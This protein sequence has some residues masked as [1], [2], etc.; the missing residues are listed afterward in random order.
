[1]Y[2]DENEIKKKRRNL[3][4]GIAVLLG[5]ILLLIIILVVASGSKNKKTNYVEPTCG[6]K[7]LD[8]VKQK[9]GV[10]TGAITIGFDDSKITVSK[11]YTISSK[12]VGITNSPR[13]SETYKLSKSGKTKVY[14]Y[15][16][17]S[18]GGQGV[19]EQEFEILTARPN[20]QLKVTEGTKGIDDWYTSDI[21]V[22][23]ESKT[24]ENGT[25]KSYTIEEAKVESEKKEET[26][27][28]VKKA[29]DEKETTSTSK[30]VDTYTVKTNGEVEVVG[31]VV[32]DY[33]I[34]ATCS[35]KV[36]KDS[37][38]P[39]CELEV[40]S[41]TKGADGRYTT[42]VVV[43][44]AKAED[45]AS[46]VLE[47]GVGVK[48]NYKDETY[49]V[50]AGGKTLVKGFVKDKAGNVGECSLEINI[51]G[52]TDPNTSTPS[53]KLKVESAKKDGTK[54]IDK[55]VVTFASKT[56]DKNAQ[57]EEYGIS[58]SAQLNKT[59]NLTLTD[60]GNYT[61]YGMVRD[62]NGRIAE[63]KESF[64]IIAQADVK[65][66][67]PSC[68]LYVDSTKQSTG[69]YAK[70]AT[71]KFRTA[72][73]TNGAT[74]VHYGIGLEYKLS[75][76]NT[77]AVG[78]GTYKVYGMVE[79]SYGH[80]AKCGPID[81]TVTT[82][83]GTTQTQTQTQTQQ[84][85]VEVQTTTTLALAKNVLKVGDIVS[86]KAY[87]SVTCG[88]TSDRITQGT[89]TWK[90]FKVQGDTIEL[91]TTS[92]PECYNYGKGVKG[93][94]AVAKLNER[95]QAYLD[96]NFAK[97]AR[98]MN[99]QDALSYGGKEDK[100]AG[101]QRN[102][103]VYYWLATA[104]SSTNQIYGVR[105]AGAPS[106]AGFVYEGSD[107]NQGI[108]PI[109]TLKSGLYAKKNSSGIWVLSTTSKGELITSSTSLYDR[110]LD[111]VNSTLIIEN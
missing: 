78:P 94:T 1:M 38:K 82:E 34:D 89:N 85:T 101:A 25:I 39:T 4:L 93:S 21:V 75:G 31:T 102:T 41:G 54:H 98:A 76:N 24:V 70:D 67:T 63:C 103:G 28:E 23:F 27:E 88:R 53:C 29:S 74:I 109:V 56:T 66:S 106:V 19:C 96:S 97:S 37:E 110:I 50:T 11:G 12:K 33:G 42:S 92:I 57:I 32:D 55:V 72:T 3:I 52:K 68:S 5:L 99:L 2:D 30:N 58:T 35:L 60:P 59:D 83:A 18:K 77:F 14:G 36:K 80:I 64:T 43:G 100:N 20:C 44:F 84:Q 90:V 22:G 6:L 40:R 61:V 111:I 104:G 105:N 46:G 51:S 13:N 47:Q 48:E 69:T 87:R 73:S 62:S 26:K 108:R 49:T 91:I 9:D 10:Y 45:A 8:D 107:Y 79:D 95:A 81:F 86:Y 15:I 7:V 65:E 16:T 71:V 17:D